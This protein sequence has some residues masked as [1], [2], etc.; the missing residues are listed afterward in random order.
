[1]EQ[2]GKQDSTSFFISKTSFVMYTFLLWRCLSL[3]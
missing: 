1:V 3:L 2:R